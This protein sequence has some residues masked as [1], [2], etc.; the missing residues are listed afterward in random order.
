VLSLWAALGGLAIG[1]VLGLLGGGGSTLTVPLL[2]ALGIEPKPAIALSL[3][4]VSATAAAALISHARAGRVDWRAA[5]WLVPAVM[6]GGFAGGR[7]AALVSGRALIAGFA[8]LMA[9]AGVSMLLARPAATPARSARPRALV[10]AGLAV[11]SITGLVGVGG[12]FLF[13]PLLALAGGLPM[14]RA[15]GTSL[16]VIAANATAALAGQLGHVSVPLD[17]ALL[18]SAAGVL[19]A[20]VGARLSG[21]LPEP[22]LRRGFGVLVLVTAAWLAARAL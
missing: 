11:G 6:L 13:V 5:A 16:L 10:A 20:V 18:L 15:I 2:L 4:V 7:A 21:R 8:L 22:V 17:L 1:L 3:A 9:A 12:G 19:G 14:Q